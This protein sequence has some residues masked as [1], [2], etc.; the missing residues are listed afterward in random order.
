MDDRIGRPKADLDTPALLVDIDVLDRNIR[1]IVETCRARG[2]N[3]RPHSKSHKS[4]DIVRR[5]LAAGASGIVCAKLGEA[6]V[7]AEAGIRNILIANQIV[8]AAKI[9]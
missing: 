3:W 9:E 4:P 5:Q 7:M 1:E 8:G 6:E 2:V